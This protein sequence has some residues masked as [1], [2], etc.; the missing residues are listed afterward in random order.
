[1]TTTYE[2]I[3]NCLTTAGVPYTIHEHVLSHMVADAEAQ[4]PFPPERLLKTIAFKTKAGG[5]ILAALRGPDR[6]DYRKLANAFESKRAD[7]VRLSPQEVFDTLGVEVGSVSP[8]VLQDQVRVVFDTRVS[9]TE[10]V[11]CGI[12]RADQTL[13]IYLA[14]L[15]RITQG[16]VLAISNATL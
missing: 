8:I 15:I 16:Q 14:D 13:E 5:Y 2:A 6:V 1:M 10:T 7:V 11:F 9:T 4:L 12:G 3:T